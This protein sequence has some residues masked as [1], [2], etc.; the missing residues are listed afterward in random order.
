MTSKE[1]Q[2]HVLPKE[3]STK[4]TPAHM[5]SKEVWAQEVLLAH[6]LPKTPWQ[7][8]PHVGLHLH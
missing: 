2:A 7:V 3:V 6:V 1:V 4:D 5:L 8:L